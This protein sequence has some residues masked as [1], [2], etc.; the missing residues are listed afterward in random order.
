MLQVVLH[1]IS[2]EDMEQGQVQY[3]MHGKDLEKNRCAKQR[4]AS[5][6]AE[7]TATAVA[8]SVQVNPP[9]QSLY[10]VLE[11]WVA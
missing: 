3:V 8:A 1:N 10:N 7:A 6:A 9:K 11:G 2:Q 4:L 5:K